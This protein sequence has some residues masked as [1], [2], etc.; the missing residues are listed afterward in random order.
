MTGVNSLSGTVAAAAPPPACCRCAA[1]RPLTLAP[2]AAGYMLHDAFPPTIF[3]IIRC[4]RCYCSLHM[5][6]GSTPPLH[7]AT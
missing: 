3:S 7:S 6:T 5:L 4:F 2:P 1:P